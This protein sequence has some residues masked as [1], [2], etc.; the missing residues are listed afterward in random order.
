MS[1]SPVVGTMFIQEAVER[2][3]A[4]TAVQPQN[5]R[6]GGRVALALHEP[7]MQKATTSGIHV[8]VTRVLNAKLSLKSGKRGDSV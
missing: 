6:I 4:R 5:K 3:A 1:V 7:I 2:R 8:D